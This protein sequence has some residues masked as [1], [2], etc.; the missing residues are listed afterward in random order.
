MS[1]RYR[2]GSRTVKEVV[3]TQNRGG[4]SGGGGNDNNKGDGSK[5]RPTRE[6]KLAAIEKKYG[7]YLSEEAGKEGS[8]TKAYND[9]VKGGDQEKIAAANERWYKT[10]LE[11][12]KAWNRAA[13]SKADE[14]WAA[15]AQS[16]YDQSLQEL[17]NLTKAPTPDQNDLPI[18]E[19][20]PDVEQGTSSQPKVPFSERRQQLVERG[21][22][23]DEALVEIDA[24]L[25]NIQALRKRG[26]L[27]SQEGLEVLTEERLQKERKDKETEKAKY[28]RDLQAFGGELPPPTEPLSKA[29]IETRRLAARSPMPT[30]PGHEEAVQRLQDEGRL[31][32]FITGPEGDRRL[33][34]KGPVKRNLL[35]A[36][37]EPWWYRPE[38][39][40]QPAGYGFAP[41]PKGTPTQEGLSEL[42]RRRDAVK[43]A[44][45]K[46]N[47]EIISMGGEIDRLKKDSRGLL[48]VPKRGFDPTPPSMRE[49]QRILDTL[50][51]RRDKLLQEQKMGVPETPGV[52]EFDPS[53]VG[54]VGL[55][56]MERGIRH[57]ERVLSEQEQE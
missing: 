50:T 53:T 41:K 9:A 1:S 20:E 33:A 2:T 24:K 56:Q 6:E 23:I 40:D 37:T 42:K 5:S 31:T 52:A 26:S 12:A 11:Y 32:E 55:Q 51:A 48:L 7:R 16:A 4:G 25:D 30:G 54:A 21:K 18:P 14:S 44:R 27:T 39:K 29:E 15:E 3:K 35:K 10:Q 19:E 45:D 57:M 38:S 8:L 34:F 28:L 46:R 22:A 17:N 47:I 13:G 36:I 43:S 49:E